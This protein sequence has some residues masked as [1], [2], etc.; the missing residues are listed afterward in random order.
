[1]VE[2]FFFPKNLV[3]ETGSI[4]KDSETKFLEPKFHY[5]IRN[6]GKV[7]MSSVLFIV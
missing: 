3:L 6:C 5:D 1:M 2:F 7:N 4:G